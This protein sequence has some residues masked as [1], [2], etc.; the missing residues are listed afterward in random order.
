[1]KMTYKGRFISVLFVTFIL[2]TVRTAVKSHFGSVP[3]SIPFPAVILILI[4]W[5]IGKEYDKSVYKANRDF[6]TKLYNRR[7]VTE[8]INKVFKKVKRN[9]QKLAVILL[10]VNDFKEINDNFGHSAGDSILKSISNL[11]VNHFDSTDIVARWGGDEF[12]I[13]SSFHE[14]ESLNIKL[15]NLINKLEKTDWEYQNISLSLGHAIYPTDAVNFDP[16][17][18]KADSKMYAFKSQQNKTKI[19]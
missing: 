19:Q 4:G 18:L 5:F 14:Q 2:L 11:L 13:L 9:K 16:L 3:H 1:M 17:V 7:F 15:T 12:L 8:R 10:D 6:L